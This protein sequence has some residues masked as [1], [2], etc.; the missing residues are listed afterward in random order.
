MKSFI[1][2]LAMTPALAPA[3]VG[4]HRHYGPDPIRP[5]STRLADCPVLSNNP[6]SDPNQLTAAEVGKLVSSA[7][8][9]AANPAIAVVVVDRG[10]RVLGVFRGSQSS[11]AIVETALSLA[12]AGAF[13]SS[14]GTPLSSRT[15]A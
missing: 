4:P 13:F 2:L 7:V 10:G 12:R 5:C 6:P 8:A 15:V 3:Q 9:A 11:S 14:M 1:L